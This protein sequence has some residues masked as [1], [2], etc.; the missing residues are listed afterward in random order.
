MPVKALALPL[1]TTRTRATAVAN[2]LRHHSTGADAVL[3]WVKTPATWVPGASTIIS[4]SVR[5]R[6]LMPALPVASLTPAS[7]GKLTV[8]LG[9]KGDF[10]SLEFAALDGVGFFVV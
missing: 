3:D 10:A 4:T 9:A 5:S 2:C 6:Y 7:G 1:F 8:V